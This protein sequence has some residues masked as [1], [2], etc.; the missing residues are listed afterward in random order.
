M[1]L[2]EQVQSDFRKVK[3]GQ[4]EYPNRANWNNYQDETERPKVELLTIIQTAIDREDT[5][6][7]LYTASGRHSEEQ[8]HLSPLLI[9]Q[10]GERYYL[11]AYCH[12]RKANRTFRLDRLKLVE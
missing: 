7:V 9:E 12:T 1:L 5:V 8:R 4:E 6:D 2:F 3:Y 11:V 10:R